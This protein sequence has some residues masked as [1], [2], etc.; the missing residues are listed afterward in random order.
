MTIIEYLGLT[1]NTGKMIVKIPEN[2]I[3]EL[4]DKIIYEGGTFF[5]I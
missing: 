1:I 5:K 2:K 4:K 3:S